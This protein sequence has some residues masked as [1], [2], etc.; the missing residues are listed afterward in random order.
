MLSG[1][2]LFRIRNQGEYAV[3]DLKQVVA[4]RIDDPGILGRLACHLRRNEPVAQRHHDGRELDV[5]WRERPG[6]WRCT[7]FLSKGSE[8]CLAQIDLHDDGT[9]RVESHEPCSITIAPDEDLLCI[10]RFK[11]N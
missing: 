3:I 6:H 8:L 10:S 9:V 7:I 11:S 1:V 5:L 4:Q 2:V